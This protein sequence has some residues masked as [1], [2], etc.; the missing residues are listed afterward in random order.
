MHH[1]HPYPC[2]MPSGVFRR[3]SEF[4]IMISFDYA[5]RCSHRISIGVNETS[6]IRRFFDHIDMILRVNHTRTK[7]STLDAIDA[8]AIGVP[9]TSIVAYDLRS[10]D[11]IEVGWIRIRI[12]I[13]RFDAKWWIIIGRWWDVYHPSR[14]DEGNAYGCMPMMIESTM[15]MIHHHSY[16]IIEK[17][18]SMIDFRYFDIS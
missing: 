15:V 8:S 11:S 1:Q 3:G 17:D 5:H 2:D 14:I 12:W 13:V 16:D 9:R 4:G 7:S 6:F 10:H 18:D